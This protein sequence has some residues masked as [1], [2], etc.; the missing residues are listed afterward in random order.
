MNTVQFLERSGIVSLC[1]VWG[2]TV[3]VQMC[4][5]VCECLSVFY[6]IWDIW[7]FRSN[8]VMLWLSSKQSIGRRFHHKEM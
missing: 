5:Y 3:K 8:K 1:E 6:E 7:G 2:Y 4:V